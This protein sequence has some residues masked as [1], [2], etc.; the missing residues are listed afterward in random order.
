MSVCQETV[1]GAKNIDYLKSC[2]E[3]EIKRA[4]LFLSR[5]QGVG[6]EVRGLSSLLL[7]VS[8]SGVLCC[9]LTGAEG[10]SLPEMSAGHSYF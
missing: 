10:E 9:R 5:V 4:P 3:P 6:G 2:T 1:I 8:G 7:F